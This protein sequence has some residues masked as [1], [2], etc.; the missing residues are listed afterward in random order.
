MK[1][2]A[3][4]FDLDGTLLDTLDDLHD[5]VNHTMDV[6][7]FPRRTSEEVRSF[8]GNGVD[9]LIELSVPGGLENPLYR[10]AIKECRTYYAANSEGKKTRP[11]DGIT[12]LIS[13]LC[14]SGVK[15]AVVSNKI[16][17]A[18]VKL[19]EK[20]FPAIA[21]AYGEREAEGV[22]RKPYPDMVYISARELGVEL[23]ECVY[24]GDSEVDIITAKNAGVDC[25]SVLWGFRDK[26]MLAEYG[27]SVFAE[28]TDEL[29]G[30]IVGKNA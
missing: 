14:E 10:D 20:H 5:M 26:A 29:Y 2:K 9:K 12:E 4:I 17:P 16:H 30:L 27:G 19:C 6:F 8:V 13:R 23:S 18:T 28:N 3:A 7:G 21:H 11:Y 25:I 24:I 22:R 15:V 1:Y